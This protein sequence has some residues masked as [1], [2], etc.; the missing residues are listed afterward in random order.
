M[1]VCPNAR[2]NGIGLIKTQIAGDLREKIL[3]AEIQPGEIISE[4]YWSPRLG[5]AQ[6]SVREAINLLEREGL[7]R[8]EPGRSARVTKLSQ[9]DVH[10]AY[11]LRAV[12]EGLVAR[13]VTEQRADLR[14]ME[15]LIQVMC[16]SA[17]KGDQ[18]R[19]IEADRDFHLSLAERTGNKFLLQ[20]VQQILT[21]LFA[22][23]LIR[24]LKYPGAAAAWVESL[25]DHR[26]ILTGIRT[27][28][29]GLAEQIARHTIDRFAMAASR[30]WA[31]EE[32]PGNEEDV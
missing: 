5:A 15:K 22:F 30:V 29:P 13:L 8:K 11:Q 23:S 4:T 32:E 16:K 9:V 26:L 28:N 12:L 2:S 17:A 6:A 20:Q 25:E 27:G 19:V 7:V 31:R 14:P 21:P 10:H 24:T 18:R 3:N 1:Q